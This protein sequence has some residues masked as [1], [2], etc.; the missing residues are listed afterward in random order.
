MVVRQRL[1]ELGKRFTPHVAD[2][3]ILLAGANLQQLHTESDKLA[4]YVGERE[5]VTRQDV[6]RD[7]HTNQ[8]GS[9]VCAGRRTG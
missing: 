3:L 8:A 2:E 7:C 6:P 5:E 4:A 1:D 9:G